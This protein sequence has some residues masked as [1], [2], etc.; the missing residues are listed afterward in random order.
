MSVLEF[1]AADLPQMVLM[2]TVLRDCPRIKNLLR[3]R[4]FGQIFGILQHT[5]KV[6]YTY[7]CHPEGSEARTTRDLI[8]QSTKISPAS[9]WHLLATAPILGQPPSSLSL[10]ERVGVRGSRKITS[11]RPVAAYRL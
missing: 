3:K 8:A 2:T 5:L 11:L 10:R 9:R 4:P 1:K 6:V 7:R